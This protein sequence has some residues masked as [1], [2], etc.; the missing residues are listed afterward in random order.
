MEDAAEERAAAGDRAR[1]SSGLPRPV[2]SPVSE[3]PSEKPMLIAGAD[4]RREAGDERVAR[5]VRREDDAK[6]GASVD[7]EPSMSPT[8]AGWTRWRRKVC[9]SVIELEYIKQCASH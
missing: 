9:S 4:R 1:A 5:V 2:S 3:R 7:S 8:I 6:I